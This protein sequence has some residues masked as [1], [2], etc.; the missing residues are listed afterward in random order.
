MVPVSLSSLDGISHVCLALPNRLK[1][2]EN[3]ETAHKMILDV[4]N[5]FHNRIPLVDPIRNMNITDPRFKD[6]I[7]V[8]TVHPFGSYV[9]IHRVVLE[10]IYTGIK[11]HDPS[12][13]S[14]S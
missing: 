1:S 2:P 3:R 6:L 9:N 8:S 10:N 7:E 12:T 5:R 11:T 4:Q 13:Q 14:K